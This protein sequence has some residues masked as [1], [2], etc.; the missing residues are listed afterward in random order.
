M[1]RLRTTDLLG[2]IDG[3]VDGAGDR[4]FQIVLCHDYRSLELMP[5]D[6][7]RRRRGQTN[8]R[9]WFCWLLR[10]LDRDHRIEDEG[11]THLADGG[12]RRDSLSDMRSPIT[13]K[14]F[15]DENGAASCC[16]SRAMRHGSKSVRR[17]GHFPN[18][19]RAS[20]SRRRSFSG[21]CGSPAMRGNRASILL[22]VF[23]R[24]ALLDARRGRLMTSAPRFV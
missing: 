24:V 11:D 2:A 7:N 8:E 16:E 6:L 22:L 17:C 13:A 9:Q 21:N 10:G 19:P 12:A 20:C 23:R 15:W 14:R 1:A 3:A 5:F 18:S 4:G